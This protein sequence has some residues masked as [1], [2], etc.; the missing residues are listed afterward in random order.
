MAFTKPNS[1]KS[2]LMAWLSVAVPCNTRELKGVL[3]CALLCRVQELVINV[4]RYIAWSSMRLTHAKQLEPYLDHFDAAL[5][6]TWPNQ[7]APATA[8]TMTLWWSFCWSVAAVVGDDDFFDHV[9]SNMDTAEKV[10]F[11]LTTAV[12]SVLGRKLFG[13]LFSVIQTHQCSEMATKYVQMLHGARLT[14]ASLITFLAE[15]T[16]AIVSTLDLPSVLVRRVFYCAVHRLRT[17]A[18]G[19]DG[20]LRARASHLPRDQSL[21]RS[22]RSHLSSRV[23]GR[24]L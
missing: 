14:M 3:N 15:T 12:Q 20:A 13:R 19:E 18:G 23:R 24:V 4:I 22:T 21:A 16:S 10:V 6:A 2:L 9:I 11:Q 5:A 17:D 8:K 1:N 7:K